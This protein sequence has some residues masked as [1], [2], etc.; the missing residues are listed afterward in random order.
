MGVYS[1]HRL[2][3]VSQ[4]K[5]DIIKCLLKDSPY[6]NTSL[7]SNGHSNKNVRYH[8]GE[9]IDILM[10]F[11]EKYPGILF[12]LKDEVEDCFINV[13]FVMNGKLLRERQRQ[14]VYQRC[15]KRTTQIANIAKGSDYSLI[16]KNCLLDT[17][18]LWTP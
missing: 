4:N 1:Y 11:S 9:A 17:L 16:T 15:F 2:K 18:N 8:E 13:F 6:F 7:K 3:V 5:H 14:S 10:L 12:V